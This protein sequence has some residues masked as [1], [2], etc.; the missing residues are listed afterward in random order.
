MSPASLFICF[1][2]SGQVTS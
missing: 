2:L 1:T